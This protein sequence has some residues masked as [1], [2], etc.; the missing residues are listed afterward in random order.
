MGANVS[1]AAKQETK[2]CL[3]RKISTYIRCTVCAAYLQLS[4]AARDLVIPFHIKPQGAEH[5]IINDL[6]VVVNHTV[7]FAADQWNCPAQP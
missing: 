7:Q 1:P 3:G 5:Y 4:E 6:N 2:K